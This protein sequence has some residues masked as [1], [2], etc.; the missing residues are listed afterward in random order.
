MNRWEQP[1]PG[2]RES[3]DGSWR[4]VRAAFA[5][6]E[7]VRARRSRWPLV[8]AA[9]AAAVAAAALSAPGLAVL[10]SLRNAVRGER[11]ANPALFALPASGRLL[12]ESDRGTWVI[13]QD[14][15]KRL[16]A[17]YR[18]ASWSPNGLFLAALHGHELR[19]L[20]P[21]GDVHWSLAR[22]GA[23]RSPVWSDASPPCCRIGYL[24]GDE[25]RVVDGDGTGDRAVARGVRTTRPAWQPGTHELAYVDAAGDVRLTDGDTGR[26][27]GT[28][29]LPQAPLALDWSPAGALLARARSSLTVL[30]PGGSR[31]DLVGGPLA[32]PIVDAEL[33]PDGR[34]VAFV[35]TTAGRSTL[36]LVPRLRPDGSAA[37]RVF[38]GAG[39]FS[40][41]TWSP[42]G[43]WLLLDWRS[44]GQWLFI[45]SAAV[46][47]IRAVSNI[48]G[49]FGRNAKIAGWCCP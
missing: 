41:V 18:G 43:K 30:G 29:G 10:D 24:A 37:R 8:A 23:L 11:N 40:G 21:G 17:G 26:A 16:L 31:H 7:P 48:A 34:Q 36:W 39:E 19:A 28:I 5:E 22:P 35:Q 6:R 15:S 45:R 4:I 9:A 44:A 46:R 3:A 33:S 14:G 13:Q 20:E 27:L 25:L 1:A 47:K 38:T 42:D 49:N 2:E 32:A 12:V